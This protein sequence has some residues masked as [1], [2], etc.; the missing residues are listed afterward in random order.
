MAIEP[1]TPAAIEPSI[2]AA[3]KLSTPAIISAQPPS[4]ALDAVDTDGTQD[5]AVAQTTGAATEVGVT[6]YATADGTTDLPADKGESVKPGRIVSLDVFRGMTIAAMV[7][8]NNSGGPSY[9]PLDHAEWNGWTHTDLI[10]PFFMFIAGAS[11]ALSFARRVANPTQSPS[12]GY[13]TRKP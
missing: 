1:S 13:G 9:G 2:P 8:V 10:F 4:M 11:M 6:E 3:I 7:L 5:I 12:G